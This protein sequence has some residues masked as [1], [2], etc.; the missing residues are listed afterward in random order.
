MGLEEINIIKD[1]TFDDFMVGESNKEAYQAALHCVTQFDNQ[2]NWL[3]IYSDTGLGGTHLLH[4]IVNQLL[5]QQPNIRIKH[6]HTE[7]LVSSY[8]QASSQNELTKFKERYRELD[9]LLLDDM[10]YLLGFGYEHID[11]Q[12]ELNGILSMLLLRKTLI[13]FTADRA[14]KELP[15]S[16]AKHL[17]SR[18]KKATISQPE[19]TLKKQLGK[20]FSLQN[21]YELPDEIISFISQKV[22]SN[23]RVLENL[24]NSICYEI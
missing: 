13:F 17:F 24:V 22:A 4:A 3:W 18:G 5:E 10:Q 12:A 8:R 1:R 21:G 6:I 19:I 11:A 23:I 14:I 20:H 15:E 7:R 2:H 16:D 9:C